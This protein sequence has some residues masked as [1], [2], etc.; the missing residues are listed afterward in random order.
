MASEATFESLF[1]FD[2]SHYPASFFTDYEALAC[3]SASESTET[4]IVREKSTNEHRLAKCYLG[5]SMSSGATEAT[6]LKKLSNP[7][8]PRFLAEYQNETMFCVIREYIEGLPLNEYVVEKHPSPEQS[9]AIASQ[10]CDILA[11]LHRQSP[12]IIHRD[13]KPQNIIIDASEKAWLI[14]FGISREYNATANKDTTCFGTVDFA[15]PEQYG[16]SQTDSRADIFSLGVLIGWLLTGESK[17]RKALPKLE[18]T[19]I[20]KIV[21]TCTELAPDRRYASADRVKKALQ[22]ANGHWQRRLLNIACW[23]LASIA[24]LCAGFAVG[25]YTSYTP[26]LFAPAAVH[27]SEPLIEQAVRQSL[28]KTSDEPISNVDLLSVTEL[29][30]FGNHAVRNAEAYHEVQSRMVQNDGTVKNGG[31]QSLEDLKQLKNLKFVHIALQ[32]ITDLSPLAQLPALETIDLIHNPVEDVSPLSTLFSLHDLSLFDSRVSD[33]SVL[34]TC[35]LLNYIDAGKTRVTS[36]RAF[37]GISGL[38]QLSLR[39]TSLKSLDG[40]E[41]LSGLEQISLGAVQ[42]RDL[43]ALNSL[44]LLEKVSLSED[45]RKDAARDLPDAAFEIVYS[46]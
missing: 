5:E 12:P 33:F 17:P 22:R 11:Y 14:D 16:F 2:E 8:I 31:I 35:P 21:K 36:L 40:I 43:T 25:R 15:P 28:Q 24:C 29:Y 1:E 4:L 27:F 10:V 41:S 6:L 42:S 46:D 7:G 20:K 39:G 45:L 26:A 44:P 9:V 32:D 23:L 37:S 13:I 38:T 19:Q 30:I 18:S 3:L 34:S